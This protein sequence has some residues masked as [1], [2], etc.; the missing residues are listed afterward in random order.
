M[1]RSLGG[2]R[3]A[4]MAAVVD[5]QR[6]PAE[7]WSVPCTDVADSPQR[8]HPSRLWSLTH[9]GTA[10]GGSAPSYIGARLPLWKPSRA[11]QIPQLEATGSPV[12]SGGVAVAATETPWRASS[13]I[14]PDRLPD[15]REHGRRK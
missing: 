7:G 2:R 8:G 13:A 1:E 3:R 9:P 15:E 5:R 6:F 11:I 10:S 4:S 12:Q 14:C